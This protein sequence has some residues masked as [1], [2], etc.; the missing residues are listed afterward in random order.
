VDLTVLFEESYSVWKS[1]NSP[2]ELTATKVP[3]QQVACLIHSVPTTMTSKEYQTL[4]K[5]AKDVA[6]TLFITQRSD[7][8]YEGFGRD[9]TEFVGALD[10]N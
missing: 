5:K 6:G 3:R 4:V 10:S 8:V 2:K 7:G 1:R 9:W